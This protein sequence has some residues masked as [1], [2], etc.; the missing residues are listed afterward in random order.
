MR[1]GDP[2][3]STAKDYWVCVGWNNPVQLLG[4]GRFVLKSDLSGN[5]QYVIDYDYKY[6]RNV[7]LKPHLV[8]HIKWLEIIKIYSTDSNFQKCPRALACHNFKGCNLRVR[9]AACC[10]TCNLTRS[11]HA[12]GTL[13]SE[14]SRCPL[15]NIDIDLVDPGIPSPGTANPGFNDT[16]D[17]PRLNTMEEYPT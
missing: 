11:W 8:T 9:R 14:I 5:H 6:M 4:D 3:Q 10:E 12:C 17:V 15:K 16:L 13:A 2:A 7:W 1:V